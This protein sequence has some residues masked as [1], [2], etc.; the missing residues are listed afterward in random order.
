MGKTPQFS[1]TLKTMLFLLK[2]VFC[3]QMT[4][5][6]HHMKRHESWLNT[7]VLNVKHYDE[8]KTLLLHSS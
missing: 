8:W 1:F 7:D 5:T 6:N 2:M 3:F 4:H